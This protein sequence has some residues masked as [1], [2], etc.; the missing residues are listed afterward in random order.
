[1][2][3]KRSLR[4]VPPI[5]FPAIAVVVEHGFRQIRHPI[6]GSGRFFPLLPPRRRRHYRIDYD[7]RRLTAFD[8]PGI[9]DGIEHSFT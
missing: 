5:P 7:R 3:P 1:L 6:G 9:V 8:P 4:P 2:L